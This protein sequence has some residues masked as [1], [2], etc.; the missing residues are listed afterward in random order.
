MDPITALL[1]G[2]M[3]AALATKFVG[4]TVQDTAATIRGKTPPTMEKWRR[5][6][7]ARVARGLAREARPPGLWR[8]RWRF[9]V[10]E[11]LAKLALKHRARMEHLDEIAPD[12]VEKHKEKLRRRATR[13]D[14]VGALVAKWG[15]ASWEGAKHTAARDRAAQP[16]QDIPPVPDPPAT[17]EAAPDA[18]VLPFPRLVPD[19][20]EPVEKEAADT[21]DDNDSSTPTAD[22][23]E[24]TP[25][26]ATNTTNTEITDLETAIT[27]GQESASYTDKVVAALADITAQVDAAMQGLTAEAASQEQAKASL[28]GEGFGEKITGRY[29]TAGEALNLAAA[30]L[31][32]ALAHLATAS[33]QASA[34]GGEM[35][36]AV[37]TFSDQLAVSETVGAAKQDSGVSKRTD[38]YAPA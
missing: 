14:T 5:R 15:N 2:S 37:T 32:T 22:T 19:P 29:D 25:M 17:A 10:E 3:F 26:D 18:A 7:D 16:H 34:A 4:R 20:V 30:A 1:L 31:K 21:R 24:G 23:T 12:V 9:G 35:R 8:T 13:R 6:Q 33:E 36:G 11:H 28:S 27:H 38:F